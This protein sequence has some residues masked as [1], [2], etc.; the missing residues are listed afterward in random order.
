MAAQRETRH[1]FFVH[2]CL[3][4]AAAALERAGVRNERVLVGVSGGSDSMAL[5]EITSMLAPRLGL[6]MHVACVDHGLRPEA[7][8]EQ[9]L[10]ADAAG[11]LG[12]SFHALRVEPAGDDEDSLRRAR[13]D[14]LEQLRADLGCRFLL[15]GHTANDQ[16]E[17]V[18]FRFLRG[19]GIGG[20]AGMA[21]VRG[22]IVR[23]LLGLRR[24]ELRR[25]LESRGVTWVEDPTNLSPRYARGLLRSRVLPAVASAFG[26]GALDHLLDVAPRWRADEDFLTQETTRLLAYASRRG[27]GRTDLDLEALGTAHHA[28]RARALRRWILDSTGR[29][30]S[31]RDIAAIERWLDGGSGGRSSLDLAGG[32]LE[33]AG[34]RLML[35][36][37]SAAKSES[38]GAKERGRR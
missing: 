7:V 12:A 34:G 25:L 30:P 31:S 33:R 2:R 26:E 14:A 3:R 6:E 4:S 20:L 15:L 27:I 32:R 22:S 17:T 28:I 10:V 29:Q 35:A 24:S 36:L 13:L 1:P 5:A 8:A 11:R 21:E 9:R 38:S 23:P 37:P 18:V 19:A 16:I